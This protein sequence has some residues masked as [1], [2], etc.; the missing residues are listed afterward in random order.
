M[1]H[2]V[3]LKAHSGD[4]IF[5]T[6]SPPLQLFSPPFVNGAL[7]QSKQRLSRC[8]CSAGAGDAVQPLTITCCFF[9]FL[10]IIF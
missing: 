2:K 5:I 1:L 10:V 4:I 6:L 3:A 9:V 7:F 8:V